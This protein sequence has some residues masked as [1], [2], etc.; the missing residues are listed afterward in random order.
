MLPPWRRHGRL[1]MGHGGQMMVH[2]VQALGAG[3]PDCSATRRLNGSH[4]D[5]VDQRQD[6][7]PCTGLF[8]HSE[9]KVRRG[10]ADEGRRWRRLSRNELKKGSLVGLFD[11]QESQEGRKSTNQDRQEIPAKDISP[12]EQGR[13]NDADH[14]DGGGLRA[15]MEIRQR[16]CM[17]FLGRSRHVPEAL[18]AKR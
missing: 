14:G 18:G 3:C 4:T 12:P 17:M 1:P 13:S 10:G 15:T 5:T 7:R 16:V 8:S 9:R 2:H 11:R 6:S